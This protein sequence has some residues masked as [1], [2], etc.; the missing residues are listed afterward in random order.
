MTTL[1]AGSVRSVSL[2]EQETA[3]ARSSSNALSNFFDGAGTPLT[4][5]LENPQTGQQIETTVPAT[6]VSRF[7]RCTRAHSGRADRDAHSA[8]CRTQHPTGSRPLEC[9][10]ALFHQDVGRGQDAVSQSGRTAAR[11]LSRLAVLHGSV[12]EGG[13]RGA[14]GDDGRSREYGI[15]QMTAAVLDACV[16]YSAFLR[17]LFLRLAVGFVFQPKWTAQIQDE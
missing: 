17:D 14:G 11:S 12:P 3:L 6:A 13:E 8:S 15:V 4:L 2:P 9:F 16:L 7:S 1:L 10:T 5:R